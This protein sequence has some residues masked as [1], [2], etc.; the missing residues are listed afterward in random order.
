MMEIIENGWGL[1][2]IV[3]FQSWR[4]PGVALL[5]APFNYLAKEGFY[6]LL[7]PFLY[8]CVKKSFGRRFMLLA[9]FSA[10]LNV[11]LKNLWMRPRPFQLEDSPVKPHFDYSASYGIPSGHAMSAATL[12]GYVAATLRRRWVTVA[13]VTFTVLMA[14]SR[15]VHGV[16]FP[17][18]VV[19]GALLG[20]GLVLGYHLLEDRGAAF[21]RELTLAGQ[22]LIPLGIGIL[23]CVLYILSPTDSHGLKE[24]LT[25]AGVLT[26]GMVGS[27]LEYRF[28]DFDEAGPWYVRLIR[29]LVGMAGL[30]LLYGVLKVFESWML[31]RLGD[32]E[33]LGQIL[34]TLRYGCLGIW[35]AFAAPWVFKKLRLV[36]YRR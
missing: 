25:L 19:A 1:D 32:P 16:H 2:L 15:M 22:I 9:L 26:G 33:L 4:T 11:Y 31:S 27:A 6:L 14:A 34:R 18:D 8:W 20:G 35:V 21:F 36:R 12:S 29:Y 13:A 5:F 23:L 10:W 30:G 3:W 28:L 24:C 17:Q 7:F